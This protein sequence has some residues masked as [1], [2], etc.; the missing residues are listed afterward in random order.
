MKNKKLVTILLSVFLILTIAFGVSAAMYVYQGGTGMSSATKG[1]VLTGYDTYSL[2]ATS[3]IF[4]STASYVGIGTTTPESLLSVGTT[5]GSQFLVNS[6][7]AI[8]AVTLNTGQGANE[9]YDMNQNVLTTSNPTFNDLTI[10]TGVT[11]VTS[12]WSGLITADGDLIFND[13]IK[14]DGAT[15]GNGQ[16]LKRISIIAC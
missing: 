11:G 1:Y 14:P 12:T 8:T 4:I 13:E 6:A 15:C 2:Q 7:G 16:I 9:L 5:S 3:S 10:T